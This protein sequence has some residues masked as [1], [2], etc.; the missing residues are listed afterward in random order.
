[1]MFCALRRVRLVAKWIGE[2]EYGENG[3]DEMS[4]RDGKIRWVLAKGQEHSYGRSLILPPSTM[5][6][7]E[8]D[9]DFVINCRSRHPPCGSKRDSR[10]AER[11]KPSG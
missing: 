5:S 8:K 7:L 6:I 9:T 1:M 4:G 3:R 2:E 10:T 11:A